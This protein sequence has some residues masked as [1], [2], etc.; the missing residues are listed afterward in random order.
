MFR[1]ITSKKGEI[2]FAVYQEKVYQGRRNNNPNDVF[3]WYSR[4]SVEADS[5]S[6][7]QIEI[8]NKGWIDQI[9][10]NE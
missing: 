2:W 6:E 10:K 8:G 1:V 7:L 5:Y 4:D 9:N 3:Q